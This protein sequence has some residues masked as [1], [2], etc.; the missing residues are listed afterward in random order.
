MATIDLGKIQPLWRGEFS[1]TPATNYEPLDNLSYLDTVYICILEADG[2]QLPTN[3]T[4]FRPLIDLT[5]YKLQSILAFVTS[6]YAGGDDTKVAAIVAGLPVAA[7]DYFVYPDDF[8]V[9]AKGSVTGTFSDPLVFDPDTGVDSGLSGAL[10]SVNAITENEIIA[11]QNQNKTYLITGTSYTPYGDEGNMIIST[12]A[13]LNGVTNADRVVCVNPLTSVHMHVEAQLFD[14]LTSE[15]INVGD[16]DV[17]TS[18]ATTGV[19]TGCNMDGIILQTGLISIYYQ[20]SAR[21]S[22]TTAGT[23]VASGVGLAD[24]RLIL[25][26][27]G[28]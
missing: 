14:T 9:Y 20:D 26:P 7:Y 10:N 16:G 3:T 27:R 17:E 21:L 6:Q 11:L 22:M 1:P 12:D 2:S 15:W 28:L 13:N 18:G 24:F 8:R 25:T 5:T 4:Y 23:A 19:I